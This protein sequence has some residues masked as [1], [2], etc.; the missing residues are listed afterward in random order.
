M[1]VPCI[2]DLI[3]GIEPFN[4]VDFQRERAALER[5]FLARHGT[6][7]EDIDIAIHRGV[8]PCHDPL[9]EAWVALQALAPYLD[10]VDDVIQMP[11]PS[12]SPRKP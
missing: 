10:D 7:A 6:H 4:L 11:I 5:Q 3:G 8:L 1:A 2:D 9:V 12:E